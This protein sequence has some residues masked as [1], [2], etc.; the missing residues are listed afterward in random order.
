MHLPTRNRLKNLTAFQMAFMDGRRSGYGSAGETRLGGMN[1][2]TVRML[3]STGSSEASNRDEVA[4]EARNR[5]VDA[6]ARPIGIN[7]VGEPC[8]AFVGQAEGGVEE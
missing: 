1:R 2:Q 8:A 4:S 7:V 3:G 6:A 5:E